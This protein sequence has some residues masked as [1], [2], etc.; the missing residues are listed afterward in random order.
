MTLDQLRYF[1][2]VCKFGSVIRASEFLSI[3]QPSVSNAIISL[4]K[5]FDTLLFT[6]QNKRMM[7][8]KEGAVL[9][10][11]TDELLKKADVTVKTMKNLGN[12]CTLTLGVPPMLS[13]FILPIIFKKLPD[14]K[15]NIVED[16]RRGLM[17]LL[18]ENKINMAF[19]PHESP[20]DNR[21]SSKLLT[22]LCNVCCVGKNHPLAKKQSVTVEDL[23][24]ESLVLFK[25]SFFQTERI[26]ERYKQC[27]V[28]PYVLL[29]TV[30]VSTVQNV[31]SRGFAV[32]FIFEFLL[33]STPD[34]VGIPL[35]PPMS[36]KVSLVWKSDGHLSANMNTFIKSVFGE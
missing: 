12:S 9:L 36:T 17:R 16:D 31:V 27:G 24:N 11:H 2:A 25:N 6:R 5:E 15:I 4:E 33:K 22:E 21:Y 34:L 8:T 29:D 10:E 18:D 30:Q 19:L 3:S 7:L 20:F 28:T 32:G 23:K 35:N 1:Q 14:F 13:S 26:L